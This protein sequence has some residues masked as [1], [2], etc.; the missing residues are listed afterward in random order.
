M[1]N[2]IIILMSYIL[3]NCAFADLIKTD[4]EVI[5]N[6]FEVFG[7]PGH[8]KMYYKSGTVPD[9]RGN[10]VTIGSGA[11]LRG[12][13][14]RLGNINGS[15]GVFGSNTVT[16]LRNADITGSGVG[17]GMTIEL[18]YI[19]LEGA[20]ATGI[21]FPECTISNINFAKA[22][23]RRANFKNSTLTNVS[24]DQA[25]LS[26]ANLEGIK[27]SDIKGTPILPDGYVIASIDF[28][29]GQSQ[30]GSIIG[31]G[32]DLSFLDGPAENSTH[33]LRAKLIDAI[34]KGAVLSGIILP[35]GWSRDDIDN[36]IQMVQLEELQRIQQ[37]TS[38]I[39][40]DTSREHLILLKQISK[41][42]NNLNAKINNL[43]AVVDRRDEQIAELKKRP[44]LDAV[45]DARAGSV[46]LSVNPEGNDITLGITIEESDN[47]LDWTKLKGE[48]SRT[49]PIPDGK[50]FYRFALD[51]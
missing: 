10:P 22:D 16:D 7:E 45:R 25:D 17:F 8:T 9:A 28:R 47:L 31:P 46:V 48:M 44:T 6:E 32:V 2:S 41:E 43:Q 15:K 18:E 20:D 37:N 21:I 49:I 4:E 42:L 29:N 11:T 36:L 24:F 33:I 1:K 13:W 5:F 34:K 23:L 30:E 39:T 12:D 14:T 38:K 3:S 40:S 27:S 26:D 35:K 19:D 50:K 51:K